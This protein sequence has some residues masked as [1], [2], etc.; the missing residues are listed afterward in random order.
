MLS[1]W[2]YA[3]DAAPRLPMAV[4]LLSMA[5]IAACDEKPTVG[6][7]VTLTNVCDRSNDGKRVAVEGYLSLPSS[8]TEGL[9]SESAPVVIRGGI[10]ESGDVTFVWIGYGSGPNSM[11]KVP[12]TYSQRDLKVY[13]MDGAAVGYRDKVR[14]SGTVAFPSRRPYEVDTSDGRLLDCGLN[15]PLIERV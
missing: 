10:P 4:A 2:K 9:T 6:A 12:D 5:L 13:T 1:F 11:E 8:F 7:P 3:R 14:V 15:T